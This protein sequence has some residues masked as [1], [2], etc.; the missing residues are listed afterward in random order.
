MPADAK[1][2]F[3]S[4]DTAIAT[5]D[6]DGTVHLHKSGTVRI[7]VTVKYGDMTKVAH[8]DVLCE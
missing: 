1:T 5:V 4:G 3:E 6:Q 2:F 8:M 7:S